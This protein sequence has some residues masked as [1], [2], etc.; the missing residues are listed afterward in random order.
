MKRI[1]FTLITV[2]SIVNMASAQWSSDSVLMG[3]GS[4]ND[5]FYSLK[6]GTVKT[7][8]NKNWHLA[9]SMSPSDSGSIWANHN[10]GNSY[11]TVYNIHKTYAQWSSVTIADTVGSSVCY[12]YDK[13]WFQGALN[14]LPR[15]SIFSF[16]WGTYN[17]TSHN[18]IGDSMFIVKADTNYYKVFIHSLIS[19][20]MDYAIS[21]ENLNGGTL[22]TDTI[23]R[24][25]KYA[26]RNFAYYNLATGIDSNREPA[27][28]TWD[29]VFNR[30]NTL[31]TQGSVTIPYPVIGALSNKTIKVSKANMIH[32]DSALANLWNLGDY[33]FPWP[34]DSS[35]ISGV[36]YDWKTPPAG[37]PPAGW[38]VPD[39][40]SY[41][42]E[43]YPGSCYQLQ[44]TGYS[45]SGT[46]KIYL[47]KRL[48]APVLVNDINSS[49]SQ[50]EFFP[51]PVQNQLSIILDSK[52]NTQANLS[53]IALNG[54]VVFA[55]P[56]KINQGFN[57]YTI[58]TSSFSNGHYIISLN[59]K[60]IKVN[61]KIT[62]SK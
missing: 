20:P 27:K 14:D 37:P 16:G 23:S 48:V 53:I 34:A 40:V 35:K 62:I 36:G 61:Q 17:L 31:A 19:V 43:D 15:P 54:Q 22:M 33:V 42:I 8:N 52:D 39:S 45:G 18:V 47:R 49:L 30:Y 26:D 6:N 44:F 11:V 46:G 4:A 60:N 32:V 7:E 13:G 55:Q 24:G 9:F 58:N 29:L 10:V 1:I 56:V 51:N 2:L 50:Y 12:N 57:N 28:P 5:V 41:F 21:V 25:T 3:A 38:V 59:G